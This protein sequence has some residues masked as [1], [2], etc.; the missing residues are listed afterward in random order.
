MPKV[1]S[2]HLLVAACLPWLASNGKHHHRGGL[3]AKTP[4]TRPTG[5]LYPLKRWALFSNYTT[6][7]QT[8]PTDSSLVD[9]QTQPRLP[10]TLQG[11]ILL[12]L[13]PLQFSLVTQSGDESELGCSFP[14]RWLSANGTNRCL[15]LP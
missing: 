8:L 9:V 12:S 11:F 1:L 14:E 15:L 2:N 5:R 13:F 7:S 4:A 6:N 3:S 10:E